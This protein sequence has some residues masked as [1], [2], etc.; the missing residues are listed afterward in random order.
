MLRR[1]PNFPL[2]RL[3]RWGNEPSTERFQTIN[4]SNDE[5]KLN[6]IIS[7]RGEKRQ[8]SQNVQARG[9]M[10]STKE[11]LI[12]KRLARL[13]FVTYFWGSKS[14]AC[15]VENLFNGMFGLYKPKRFFLFNPLSTL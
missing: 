5:Q 10:G 6:L 9:F 11:G 14:D 15:R 2:V 8:K 12:V 1:I 13:K 3:F 4:L 7:L